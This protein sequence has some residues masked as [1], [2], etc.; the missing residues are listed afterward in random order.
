MHAQVTKDYIISWKLGVSTL[1]EFWGFQLAQNLG[2]LVDLVA[3]KAR[4]R[5]KTWR[6]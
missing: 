5:E 3:M 2:F 6:S 1:T 4:V